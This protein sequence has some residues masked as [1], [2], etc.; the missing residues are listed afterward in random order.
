MPLF[1]QDIVKTNKRYVTK[2]V[3]NDINVETTESLTLGLTGSAFGDSQEIPHMKAKLHSVWSTIT[4]PDQGGA[5]YWVVSWRDTSG[6]DNSPSPFQGDFNSS[7]ESNTGTLFVKNTNGKFPFSDGR[8][9][10]QPSVSSLTA[11]SAIN[12][13]IN[14]GIGEELAH[15]TIILEFT[16]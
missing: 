12:V 5:P 3:A 15:G 16:A 9:S 2:I 11:H 13:T 10:F 14:N 1:L 8:F 7:E 4:N 6:S